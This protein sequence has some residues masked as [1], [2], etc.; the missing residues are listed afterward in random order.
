MAFLRYKPENPYNGRRSDVVTHQRAIELQKALKHPD[1]LSK[2]QKDYISHIKSIHLGKS[3][4]ERILET[5][6]QTR[7]HWSELPEKD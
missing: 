4:V 1:G 6:E 2:A 3:I 5:K 7:I